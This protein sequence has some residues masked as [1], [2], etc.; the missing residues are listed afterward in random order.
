MRYESQRS[1]QLPKKPQTPEDHDAARARILGV[2][3]AVYDTEGYAAVTMRN[4]ARRTGYSPAG[5]YRY[6][7][8]H[9]ELVRAIWQDAVDAMRDDAEKASAAHEDP[10]ERVVAILES[11]ARFAIDEPAAFRSTF[12]QTA[13]PAADARLIL[14]DGPLPDLDPR[15]GTSYRLLKEAVSSAIS[16]G[17]MKPMDA[18][19]ATQTLWGTIHGVVALP[20]HFKRFP[21]ARQ[22]ER[23]RVAIRAMLRGLGADTQ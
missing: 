19:L 8:N 21:L 22:N 16:T 14:R 1:P 20:F 5:L 7:S 2:A 15:E 6:F 13:V 9:L 17:R 4:I 12:L 23:I 11:Y 18:D 3:R 10:I